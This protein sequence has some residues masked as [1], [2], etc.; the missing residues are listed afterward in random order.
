VPDDGEQI[1]AEFG[2]VDGIFPAAWAASQCSNAPW[3]WASWASS[4]TGWIAPV[5]LLAAITDTR[6]VSASRAAAKVP[7]STSPSAP[8]GTTVSR[9]PYQRA[10]ARHVSRIAGCS[11]AWVIT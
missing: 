3:R 7:G 9:T 10:K 1:R 6:T 11:V 8:T 4:A 2:D 5:S